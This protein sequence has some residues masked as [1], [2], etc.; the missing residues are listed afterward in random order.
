MLKPPPPKPAAPTAKP[1][2]APPVKKKLSLEFSDT[3]AILER[4]ISP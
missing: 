2:T 4:K 3:S 1:G